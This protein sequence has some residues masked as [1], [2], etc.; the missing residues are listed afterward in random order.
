MTCSNHP[1][2][3][4]CRFVVNIFNPFQLSPR[5]DPSS[6]TIWAE[7]QHGYQASECEGWFQQD[8]WVLGAA[9]HPLLMQIL[10]AF[11]ALGTANS[12]MQIQHTPPRPASIVSQTPVSTGDFSERKMGGEEKRM[13]SSLEKFERSHSRPSR[14]FLSLL[15]LFVILFPFTGHQVSSEEKENVQTA[16]KCP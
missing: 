15:V 1:N 4:A 7:N 11:V 13:V 3:L 14:D 8:S 9:C 5:K 6:V 12:C 10:L 2:V 16:L